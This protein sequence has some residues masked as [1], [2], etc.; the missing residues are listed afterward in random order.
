MWNIFVFSPLKGPFFFSLVLFILSSFFLY[1]SIQVLLLFLPCA[2]TFLSPIFT[3]CLHPVYSGPE[4]MSFVVAL[5]TEA[6]ISQLSQLSLSFLLGNF[7]ILLSS[8]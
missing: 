7:H 6:D 3:C 5:Y 4:R 8:E 1:L 2:T